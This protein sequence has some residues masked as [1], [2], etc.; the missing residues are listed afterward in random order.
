MSSSIQTCTICTKTHADS[1]RQWTCHNVGGVEGP[2]C[3]K[4][5]NKPINVLN[6]ALA[7]EYDCDCFDYCSL[8]FEL[9]TALVPF[10]KESDQELTKRIIKSA[11]EDDRKFHCEWTPV[12]IAA[13]RTEEKQ[14]WF[15]TCECGNLMGDKV[16]H[17]EEEFDAH[18]DREPGYNADGVWECQWCKT[19]GEE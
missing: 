12:L 11:T 18:P 4:C 2:M 6:C 16:F 7:G 13:L 1:D 9:L 15:E 17:D 19:L 3:R 10:A 14:E 8:Y 5:E